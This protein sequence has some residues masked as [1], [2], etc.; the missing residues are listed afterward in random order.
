MNAALA[1]LA[2]SSL[3]AC[4]AAAIETRPA[5]QPVQSEP[6]ATAAISRADILGQWDVVSFEG[7]EPVRMHGATRAAFADFDEQ[8]V[9]LR[10]ECNTSSVGGTVRDGRFVPQP[11]LRMQTEMGCGKEREERDERYFTFFDRSPIVERLP[12]GRLRFVAGDSVLILERPEQRR[13]AS[14]PE[15]STL[16][17]TWRMEAL[18]S[19]YRNGGEAGIGLSDVP[20]GIVIESNR[21]S[22][23]R[24]PQYDLTFNYSADGR[25][26]KTGG[27]QLPEKLDCP[28]LDYPDY[29]APA[30]PSA[31]E[32]L[33]LLHSSPWVEDV[34]NGQVLI[35]N[36]RFGLLLSD[37]KRKR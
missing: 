37:P 23:D 14:V 28:A 3:A 35:A 33:P 21:L 9:R 12:N 2:A 6:K 29:E 18:T 16:E 19:Y 20:G 32:I 36:E 5:P 22:Y 10:I 7:H 31:M 8:S 11:G 27:S 30:L 25:L 13:L 26:V 24:C 4:G 15:R 1:I 17:G 34:R